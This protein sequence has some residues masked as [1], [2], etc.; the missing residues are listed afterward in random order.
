VAFTHDTPL[1][2]VPD[3]KAEVLTTLQVG[4]LPLML[5]LAMKATEL[6]EMVE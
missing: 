3:G 1:S 2:W 4:V 5:S 6:P